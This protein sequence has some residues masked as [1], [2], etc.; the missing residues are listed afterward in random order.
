[1]GFDLY[2]KDDVLF[3]V[4]TDGTPLIDGIVAALP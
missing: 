2:V 4:F 3:Y 1:M